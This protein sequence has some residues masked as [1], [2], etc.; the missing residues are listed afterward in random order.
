MDKTILERAKSVGFSQ[1]SLA[2]AAGVH[3]QTISGLA[4][5]RRRGPVAASLR[6][7]EAALSERERAV[8]A[9]LLPRH[10]DAEM[11]TIERLLIARGLRLTRGQADAA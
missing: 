5:D 9:D 3:E 2:R 1:L 4:A 7:V 10:F 8:L 11:A 6:K